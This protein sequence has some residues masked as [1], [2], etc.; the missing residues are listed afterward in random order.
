M[1]SRRWA[2]PRKRPSRRSRFPTKR[3]RADLGLAQNHGGL[4]AQSIQL[5]SLNVGG[6]RSADVGKQARNIVPASAAAY[7]DMRMVKGNDYKRQLEL[8]VRHIQ[9]QGF[10]VL[11]REPTLEERRT[12]P[13]IATVTSEGGYNAE[14]TPLD[15]PLAKSVIAAVKGHGRAVVL[16]TLGGSL[17]LYLLRER[18]G[19]S[20]ASL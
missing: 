15:S 6:L 7:L 2:R 12:H 14:R 9:R 19:A 16:P 20:T 11:D 10:L 18:L 1:T 5:P 8:L 17:P 13:K 4:L 3:S